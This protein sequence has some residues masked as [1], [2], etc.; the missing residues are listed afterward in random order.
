[1]GDV[2]IRWAVPADLDVLRDVYRRSSLWN[3]GDRDVL[4]ANPDALVFDG[5]RL[6]EQRT[7]VATVDGVVVG[8]ATTIPPESGVAAD[9][10]ELEDL[11]VDPDWMRRGIGLALVADAVATARA[12]GAARIE[13]TAN[14]HALAFYGQAGFVPSGSIET[15][16]GPAARMRLEITR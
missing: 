4:L 6:H 15:R 5:A 9:V 10:L 14:P 11:F 13:V 8:F 3:E 2:V 7:R 16:F 12:R 1:V